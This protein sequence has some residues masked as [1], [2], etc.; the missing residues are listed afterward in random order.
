MPCSFHIGSF[1]CRI[2]DNPPFTTGRWDFVP[3]ASRYTTIVTKGRYI[4]Y[5]FDM[6]SAM[7]TIEITCIMDAVDLP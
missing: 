4:S 3:T 1:T 2:T 6:F 5:L 7:N